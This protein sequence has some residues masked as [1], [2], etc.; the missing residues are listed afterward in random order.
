MSYKR[1]HIRAGATTTAGGTVKASIELFKLNG[2]P[3]ALEGDSVDCPACGTQG[4]IKC[5]SPRIS[6]HFNGKEFALSD[7]LCIC[8]CS[9]PPKLV[10]DQDFKYQA[11]VAKP[12]EAPEDRVTDRA[13]RNA[14]GTSGA[15]RDAMLVPLRFVDSVSGKPYANRP[16]RLELKD[17]KVLHGTTDSN[18]RTRPLTSEERNGL[19]VW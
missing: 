15:T 9:P 19:N 5:V 1:Y 11:F 8:G 17:G 6:D 16:Y 14:A 4:V 10:A 12:N 13:G 18:G 7:D 2:A 3:L